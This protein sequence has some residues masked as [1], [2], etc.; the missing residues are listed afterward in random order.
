MIEVE[1]IQSHQGGLLRELRLRALKDAPD[2][3]LENYDDASKQPLEHW[4]ER[5]KKHATSPQAV[6]FFGFLNGELAGM[7]G[8]YI[9]DD[10]PGIVNLCA[11]WVAP[12]ARHQGV[13][14]ALVNRVIYW[15]KQVHASKV[16][17]WVNRENVIAAQF[18]HSCG[19]NDTGNTV[20][21]PAKSDAVE[22]EMQYG[23]SDSAEL[24][25]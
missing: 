24:A 10:E 21:F 5:A 4:Q 8:A 20:I 6:N 12:E 9:T 18:Y 23:F 15:A 19:F 16:R 2:A 11:M 1:R 13:G 17:L 3:F 25:N 14:K 22:K 7:V